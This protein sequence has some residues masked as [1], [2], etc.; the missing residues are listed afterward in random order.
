MALHLEIDP[1]VHA[2]NKQY[3]STKEASQ[4]LP[5]FGQD[6]IGRLLRE[7][8]V[9]GYRTSAGHWRVHM[10]SLQAF[11]QF[12]LYEESVR[13]ERIRY[14]RFQEKELRLL[15]APMYRLLLPQPFP[16]SL[17][18]LLAGVITGATLYF[19]VNPI[20]AHLTPSPATLPASLI[21]DVT[22]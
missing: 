14:E 12:T 2:H 11:H 20:V 13:K 18:V 3:V 17:I 22:N 19:G 6:Y 4:L 15:P 21:S 5:A 7:G 10:P 16:I 8:I 9:D 1:K